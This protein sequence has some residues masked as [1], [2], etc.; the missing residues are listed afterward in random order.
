MPNTESV[1]KVSISER[2]SDWVSVLTILLAGA[3]GIADLFG[4]TSSFPWLA[5]K[6]AA[7]VLVVI[8][9]LTLVVFLDR[10]TKLAKL[11]E[12]TENALALL[13]LEHEP[14]IKLIT[15]RE[16]HYQIMIGMLQS[17]PKGSTLLASHIEWS[18][19]P[20][21]DYQSPDEKEFS[22]IWYSRISKNELY[23]RH[24]ILAHSLDRLK[25]IRQHLNKEYGKA[26][27]YSLSILTSV[28][29]AFPLIDLVI[30]KE[31]GEALLTYSVDSKQ[32]GIMNRAI[33]IRDRRVND[34][35][36]ECFNVL[37]QRA[38]SLKTYEKV[39]WA[40]LDKLEQKYKP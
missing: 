20:F 37:W 12:N 27:Q 9:G 29:P 23:T 19:L 30:I 16:E 1:K 7:I 17:A 21:L 33:F 36:S 10:R 2:A 8:C 14:N 25:G 11:E 32:P 22:K 31:T 28:D 39:D 18:E 4:F 3:I 5:G 38:I 34:S 24:I 26:R 40:I 35:L 6:T 13:K 15:S